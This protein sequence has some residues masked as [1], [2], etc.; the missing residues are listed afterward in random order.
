MYVAREVSVVFCCLR[1]LV[2]CCLRAMFCF[3]RGDRGSRIRSLHFLWD[4]VHQE[5]FFSFLLVDTV[6]MF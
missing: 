6:V 2:A 3:L 1:V 4:R 5:V